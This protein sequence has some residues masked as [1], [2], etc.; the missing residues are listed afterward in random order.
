MKT[1]TN[2]QRLDAAVTEAGDAGFHSEDQIALIEAGRKLGACL[3]EIEAIYDRLRLEP[4]MEYTEVVGD[5]GRMY[6]RTVQAD[7]PA[8]EVLSI[9]GGQ[10]FL[11]EWDAGRIVHYA[12]AVEIRGAE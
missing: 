7:F 2:A 10:Y 6:S 4:I 5:M 11:N 8:S 12:A 9:I 3:K 1:L